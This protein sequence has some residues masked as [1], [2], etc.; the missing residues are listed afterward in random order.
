MSMTRDMVWALVQP[1]DVVK[2]KA[3]STLPGFSGVYRVQYKYD[4]SFAW[5]ITDRSDGYE[6]P[7]WAVDTIKILDSNDE[8]VIKKIR[9]E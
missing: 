7:L 2:V 9:M 6:M 4:E 5:G 8:K 1:G 3:I